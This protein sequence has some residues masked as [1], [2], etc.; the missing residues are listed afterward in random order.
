M[1]HHI[2]SGFRIVFLALAIALVFAITIKTISVHVSIL[3]L[4]IH[5]IL[6]ITTSA[7]VVSIVMLLREKQSRSVL[8][9]EIERRKKVEQQLHLQST[10]LESAANAI[11]I[12]DRDGTIVWVN[13]AFSKLT[14]YS[15]E[16]VLGKT[17]RILKSGQHDPDFYKDMWRQL[18]SGSVWQGEIFNRRKDGSLYLEEMTITPVR[19][20]GAEIS[21]FIAIKVDATERKHSDWSYVA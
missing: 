14:G 11:V 10:A 7:L 21:H 2:T 6:F 4:P 16:E 17:P 12:T 1:S 18:L 20:D 8:T 15:A 19:S 9:N 13:P 5:A 3:G